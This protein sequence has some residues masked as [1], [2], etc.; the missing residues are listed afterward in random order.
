MIPVIKQ[1]CDKRPLLNGV[2]KTLFLYLALTV[3]IPQLLVSTGFSSTAGSVSAEEKADPDE[4]RK[5]DNVKSRKRQSV[6]KKCATKLESVQKQFSGETTPNRAQLKTIVTQLQSYLTDSCTSSYEKSQIYNMLGFVHYS[7]DDYRQAVKNYRLLVAEPEAD[8]RQK[9]DTRYTLGQLYMAL[10]EYKNAAQQLEAWMEESAIVSGEGKV[11]LAHAYYQLNR[12]REA[13]TLVN[14]VINAEQAKGRVPK[15]G[16]WLLQ[17][18]LYFDLAESTASGV[19]SKAKINH[20]KKVIAILKQLIRHYPKH[21]YWY[22]LGGIYGQ[23]EEDKQRLATLD[24]LYLD[25]ALTKSRELLSLAY[26]Y[27]GA[28]VPNRAAEII[29]KGMAENSIEPSVKNLEVLGAAWQQARETKKALGPLKKAAQRSSNG[30]VWARLSMV[31]LDMDDNFNA[32][33]AARK[34]LQKG[35]LKN[36]SYTHMTL[37]NA[38]VNL[39]C[40]RDAADAFSEAANYKK[41]KTTAQQ[42]IAYAKGEAS[43]RESLIESGAKLS[44]CQLP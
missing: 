36:P 9:T 5:Y 19:S 34:A 3:F 22:E 4:G 24:I 39:Y 32:V 7:L 38:L 29:E 14:G 33:A 30:E 37:G 27:L 21:S 15:E 43:R 31:Y 41:S 28:G 1:S 17:K 2:F 26:L 12:K 11:L 44:G 35:G 20:Y 16:W 6:G 10:E 25:K 13:L 8:E 42:W 23:L 18:V 40:Y